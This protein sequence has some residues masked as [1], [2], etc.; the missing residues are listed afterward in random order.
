MLLYFIVFLR[1]EQNKIF[2]VTR[3]SPQN[4]TSNTP[5]LPPQL[6]STFNPVVV[7]P[8]TQ[9]EL[10]RVEHLP[11]PHGNDTRGNARLTLPQLKATRLFLRS[12][13]FST[14]Q[15]TYIS[16]TWY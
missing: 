4:P 14:I 2:L 16:S 1:R 11:V 13:L 15:N 8:L 5:T 3:N 10:T 12:S 7:R 9:E 6:P